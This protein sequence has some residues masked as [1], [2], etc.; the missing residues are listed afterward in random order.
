MDDIPMTAMARAALSE[1]THSPARAGATMN[2][3]VDPSSR[4]DQAME[5]M[6][7]RL[8]EGNVCRLVV[9]T[10]T[11]RFP[12]MGNTA[13]VMMTTGSAG[14]S[15][16]AASFA[17]KDSFDKFIPLCLVLV[18]CAEFKVFRY[19]HAIRGKLVLR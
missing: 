8:A 13:T 10:T 12:T 3:K 7:I 9:T 14:E 1:Y 18:G 5:A 17:V 6:K 16:G 15:T 19:L 2:G 4:S 11:R